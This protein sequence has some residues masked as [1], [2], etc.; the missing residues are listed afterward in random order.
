MNPDDSR[1]T[2][3][4]LLGF[5]ALAGF[6]TLITFPA[7]LWVSADYRNLVVR[8]AAA[9]FASV[10]LSRLVRIVRDAALIGE[11]PRIAATERSIDARRHIDPL[12]LRIA[13]EYRHALP[14]QSVPKATQDRLCQLGLQPGL[15]ATQAARKGNR[16]TWQDVTRA[17]EQH[18][19]AE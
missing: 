15:H 13:E 18:E 11:P 14:W 6:I 10:V 3:K 12:L 9:A 19:P 1:I 17:I 8:L 4:T 2:W 16:L 7:A 5:L